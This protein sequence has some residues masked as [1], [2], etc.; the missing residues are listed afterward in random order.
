MPLLTLGKAFFGNI[1][2][3]HLDGIIAILFFQFD[4]GYK[5]RSRLHNCHRRYHTLII[6]NLGHTKFNAQ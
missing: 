6:K 5:T 3:T 1:T 2:K 4:L